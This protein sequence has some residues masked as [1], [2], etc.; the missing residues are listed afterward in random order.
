MD[1]KIEGLPEN[2]TIVMP[3]GMKVPGFLRPVGVEKGAVV[4]RYVTEEDLA[5]IKPEMSVLLVEVPK[6]FEGAFTDMAGQQFAA[7]VTDHGQGCC[8]KNCPWGGNHDD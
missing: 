2:I 4:Y 5:Q 1:I 7:T 6:A 8:C 3:D